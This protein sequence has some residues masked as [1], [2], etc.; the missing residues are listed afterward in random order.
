MKRY[1]NVWKLFKEE[2]FFI[3][4]KKKCHSCAEAF[5]KKEPELL[6]ERATRMA[7]QYMRSETNTE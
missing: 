2:L 6:C 4:H 5:N 3:D 7:E 1:K